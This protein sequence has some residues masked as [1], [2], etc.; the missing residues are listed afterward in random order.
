M[1]KSYSF[2]FTQRKAKFVRSKKQF[3]KSVFALICHKHKGCLNKKLAKYLVNFLQE[4]NNAFFWDALV[5]QS[6]VD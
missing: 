6:V 5:I 4:S 3:S 2:A 1:R